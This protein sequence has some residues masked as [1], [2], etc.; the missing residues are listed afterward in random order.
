MLVRGNDNRHGGTV[1][2][3]LVFLFA[4]FCGVFG[5][6]FIKS[7]AWTTD[8]KVEMENGVEVRRSTH[9]VDW[10]R[11]NHYWRM[12]LGLS[13]ASNPSDAAPDVPAVPAKSATATGSGKPAA[14]GSGSAKMTPP[15]PA[16][17]APK[18]K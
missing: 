18:G 13:K 5:F 15:P 17:T 12:K 3:I 14:A 4:A 11:F 8:T 1:V 6:F 7:G 2:T 16:P 10:N 9:H